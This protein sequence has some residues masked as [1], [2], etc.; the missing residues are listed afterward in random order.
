M[1]SSETSAYSLFLSFFL[2]F[3]DHIWHGQAVVSL[4]HSRIVCLRCIVAKCYVISSRQWHS[5]GMA[6]LHRAT[7]NRITV[8]RRLF[9]F[10]HR[11]T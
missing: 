5:G 7:L 11:S 6:T 8:N 4:Y 1:I 3:A 10:K 2:F 9:Y